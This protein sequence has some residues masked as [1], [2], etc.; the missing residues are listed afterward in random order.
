MAKLARCHADDKPV[1]LTVE[2]PAAVHDCCLRQGACPRNRAA[3]RRSSKLVRRSCT[4]RGDGPCVCKG[5]RKIKSKRGMA[6][7]ASKPAN[8]GFSSFRQ[9][10]G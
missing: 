3:D 7:S 10:P 8:A 4:V 1:K 5:R 9:Y 2:L 6:L